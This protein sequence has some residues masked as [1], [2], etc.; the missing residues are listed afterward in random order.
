MEDPQLLQ[1]TLGGDAFLHAEWA[2]GAEMM[3]NQKDPESVMPNIS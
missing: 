2:S 3:E 1:I